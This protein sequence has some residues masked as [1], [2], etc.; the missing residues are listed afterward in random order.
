[1]KDE[2]NPFEQLQEEQEKQFSEVS[3]DVKLNITSRRGIWA[4][5]ADVIDLYIPKIISTLVNANTEK[6]SD[7]ENSF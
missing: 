2:L 4:L 1:M 3:S 7:D 5:I 6:N